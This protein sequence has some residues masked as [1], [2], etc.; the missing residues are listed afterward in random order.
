MTDDLYDVIIFFRSAGSYR[1]KR[2]YAITSLG[3][4]VLGACDLL[5]PSGRLILIRSH[6]CQK[7]MRSMLNYKHYEGLFSPKIGFTIV[8]MNK[9]IIVVDY[10]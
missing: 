4:A 8:K 9:D 6:A 7:K 5:K 1:T 10:E 3:R 2:R